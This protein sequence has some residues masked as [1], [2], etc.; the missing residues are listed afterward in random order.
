MPRN[1]LLSHSLAAIVP[2]ALHCFTSRFGMGLGGPS[3]LKSRNKSL[4]FTKEK[5][6]CNEAWKFLF[7]GEQLLILFACDTVNLQLPASACVLHVSRFTHHVYMQ[8]WKAK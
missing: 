4:F 6:K 7:A 1:G 5:N 8:R 2:S 3:A